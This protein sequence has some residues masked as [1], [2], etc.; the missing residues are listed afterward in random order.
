VTVWWLPLFACD[1]TDEPELP[2]PAD[3]PVAP[4][5]AGCEPEIRV[6]GLF[7]AVAEV[8]P[9]PDEAVFGEAPEPFHVRYSWP[10]SDPSRSAGFVWR[11]DLDTLATVVE[12]G[13]GDDLT[14][15]AVGASYT[16]GAAPEEPGPYRMHEV[17]LCSGLEPATS[18]SYRVGGEGHWS[19]VYRFTTP[20]QPD[21]LDTVRIAVTGDARGAYETWGTLLASMDAEDPDIVLFTGDMVEFGTLQAEWDAWL[22]AS[23][24]VLTRRPLIA[25]HGNHEFLAASYFAQWMFPGNEQWFEVQYG[26]LQLV[27]LNDTVAATSDLDRQAEF[28][29][30]AF[31][32]STAPWRVAMHHQSAY[33]ACTRHG[34]SERVRETWGPVWDEAGVNLVL[35]GHNHIYERS[36]PILGDR[37]VAPGEGA[38]HLVCGGAGADLYDE[39]DADAWFN[40]VADPVEHYVIGDLGPDG[41]SFVVRDLSGNEI[42]R[43]TVPI[44]SR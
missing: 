5:V 9:D 17:K 11:T 41:G 16:Y 19:P 43:F 1:R 27:V 10:G 4:P 25:A 40:A 8:A 35:A 20:A 32:A 26:P 28:Q 24:D 31:S 3:E 18:Y 15:R 7:G 13:I 12:Y 42:D 23:G 6:P 37:E 14:E 44:G 21:Q 2:G 34:S 33:S 39:Y 38:V 30:E 36:V 22:D 29:R